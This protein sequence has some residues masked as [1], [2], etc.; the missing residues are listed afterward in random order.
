[1]INW[2]FGLLAMILTAFLAGTN[3]ASALPRYSLLTGTRCSACH[4]NPQ[5][6]GLRT[7]LGFSAMNEVGALS[8]SALGL[9][10]LFNDQTNTFWN[11]LL[12]LG[13]DV[14]I[15]SAVMGR[16]PDAPRRLIPMQLSPYVAITP[17]E[18]LTFAGT[19]NAGPLR[20]GGQTAFDAQVI[21]QPSISLPSIRAGYIQPSIGI[22]HDDHTMFIRR[23]SSSNSPTP[24]IAPN[25]NELGAELTYEGE[26][27]LTVNLGVYSAKNLHAAVDI[28]DPDKPS[29]NARVILWPQLLDQGMNMELGSSILANGSFK[30]INAFGGIGLSEKATIY[31]EGM[32]ARNPDALTG[33][34]RE[35][36]NMMVQGS[37]QLWQWLALEWRYE[38]GQTEFPPE[39]P[40][41]RAQAFTM[42]FQFFPIP[43]V[44]LRPEYRYFQT[45]QYLQGQY[46]VQ[47]H[48]FY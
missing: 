28:V 34:T 26:R 47:L 37:Y 14:R 22:R 45:S 39:G 5:G 10:S 11:G 19:Y 16:P 35:I 33:K 44:E 36:R 13:M 32:Y 29:I 30:M 17:V 9:D 43:F 15:Q 42:G 18:N 38:W 31:V 4:V 23:E 12:T 46:A 20:Y 2:R 7:E 48:V 6:S 21:Y 27:W 24:I 8:P 25:Y 41:D 40:S 1:M 3:P